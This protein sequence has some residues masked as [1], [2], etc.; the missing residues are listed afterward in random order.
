[1]RIRRKQHWFL[2]GAAF[3]LTGGA[4]ALPSAAMIGSRALENAKADAETARLVQAMSAQPADAR[5]S[6]AD[7]ERAIRAGQ[8][9]MDRLA[10]EKART[11]EGTPGRP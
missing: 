2:H 4:S 3:V 11:E 7:H 6:D 1:M 5:F 8:A 10:R 9:Y